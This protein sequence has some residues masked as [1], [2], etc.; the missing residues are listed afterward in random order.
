[1]KI[2]YLLIIIL[3]IS[4]CGRQA[5][6]VSG[7]IS[8]ERSI[9]KEGVLSDLLADFSAQSALIIAKDGSAVYLPASSF[10]HIRI[11]K[12]HRKGWQSRSETL[13]VFSNIKDIAEIAVFAKDNGYGLALYDK[14]NEID[15]ITPFR[16]KIEQFEQFG[17]S[18]KNNLDAIKYQY[19]KPFLIKTTADTVL[20]LTTGG[21]YKKINPLM[22]EIKAAPYYFSAGADT[23][24]ALW[25]N[26][27]ETDIFDLHCL[28]YSNE[29][30]LL[31]IFVD[32]YGYHYHK[33][34][35]AV[36]DE[37]F[38]HTLDLKP[39]R[40]AYPPKTKYNYWAIGTGRKRQGNKDL[41]NC[42][43]R[44][45]MMQKCE[46]SDKIFTN[47]PYK[48]PVI[49]GGPFQL[50]QSDIRYIAAM[51]TLEHHDKQIYLIVKENLSDNDFVFVHFDAIDN[52]GHSYGAYSKERL[53]QTRSVAEYIK[54][55]VNAWKGDVLIFS[56]HGMHNRFGKGTHYSARYYDLIGV[57]T[58]IKQDER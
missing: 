41:S 7:N 44:C 37:N 23:I 58:I 31:T 22:T 14:E 46:A 38:L 52:A 6:I 3:I 11:Q 50:Y 54:D 2:A 9:I 32:S 43:S 1:M 34:L 45:P 8:S 24:L 13:P 15:Y 56:D 18:N 20:V 5:I 47:M 29:N 21:D 40:V 25:E 36:E 10:P 16:A 39:L 55:L 30:P 28:I 35:K 51:D 27:V 12:Y 19:D 33:H 49:I 17:R 48:S 26:Q 4:G 42:P 53:E 57:W